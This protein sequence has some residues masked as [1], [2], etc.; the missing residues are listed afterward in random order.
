[1][2]A[3]PA[4]VRV[5][6]TLATLT[7]AAE[8]YLINAGEVALTG[9]KPRAVLEADLVRVLGVEIATSLY[10]G[11]G[12]LLWLRYPCG[13]HR[14]LISLGR[15]SGCFCTAGASLLPMRAY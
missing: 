10:S 8:H 9:D 3:R 11:G 12:A 2:L 5:G 15:A 6:G 7:P 4:L 1:M 13:V 14:D